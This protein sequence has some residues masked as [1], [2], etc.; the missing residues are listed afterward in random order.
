MKTKLYCVETTFL[1]ADGPS[2]FY[3]DEPEK[4]EKFLEKECQNGGIEIIGVIS[5]YRLNYSDGCTWNE[6]VFNEEH[7]VKEVILE[8]EGW[9][10]TKSLGEVYIDEYGKVIRSKQNG[11]TVYPYRL[12]KDGWD[13]CSGDYNVKYLARLMHEGKAKWE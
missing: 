1:G 3:F 13:N 8:P 6:L 7:K 9:F 2:K 10:E 5:E 12:K 11:T 4:A